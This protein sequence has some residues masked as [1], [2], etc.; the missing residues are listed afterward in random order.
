MALG[1]S[2]LH[3]LTTASYNTAVGYNALY[4]C[5]TGS[6]NVA[7]GDTSL[8]DVT[9]GQSNTAI[10][11]YSGAD[12]D[13]G[14]Y[15]T[16]I[17]AYAG[18]YGGNVLTTGSGNTLLGFATRPSAASGTSQ[19]VISAYNN[20][21]AVVGKGNATAFITAGGGTTYNGG[22]TTAW[23]TVSDRRIKKNIE[24]NNSGLE[25]IK[26]IQVRN[27]EYRLPEEIEELDED[28]AVD[29]EGT[30]IGVIAQELMEVIPEA[31]T[32][33]STGL[34]TVE[35]DP[36]NWYLVNAVKELSAKVEELEDKLK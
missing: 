34:Y 21:A 8:Y 22:N 6:G 16:C 27:F 19:L 23:D 32:Q 11:F 30:Q 36:I 14:I 2:T 10:G 13:A 18:E 5:T 29:K 33:Q 1:T 7:V 26:N 35:A 20:N 25:K 28:Q 9:T 15:N 24:D 4:D 31:V 3:T 12:I 17:G